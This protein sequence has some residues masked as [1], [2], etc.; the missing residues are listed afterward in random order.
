[1]A[2]AY[3]GRPMG[4]VSVNNLALRPYETSPANLLSR[5]SNSAV[6]RSGSAAASGPALQSAPSGTA[7][8]RYYRK[9]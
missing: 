6:V 2:E 3:R 9:S 1:M 4:R 8:L 5:Y 7:G